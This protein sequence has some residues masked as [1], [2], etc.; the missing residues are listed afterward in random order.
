MPGGG[1]RPEASL[2]QG[3]RVHGMDSAEEDVLAFTAFPKEHRPKPA[4]TNCLGRLKKEI[5]RWA[6]VV[7]IF[8]DNAALIRL[9][10]AV[11]LE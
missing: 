4:P 3:R 2:C 10:G 11:L 6:N 9:I 1:R 7:A 5:K 8:P